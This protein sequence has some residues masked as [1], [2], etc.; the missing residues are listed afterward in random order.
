MAWEE[1]LP[2]GNSLVSCLF[3]PFGHFPFP[4]LEMLAL[5]SAVYELN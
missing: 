5:L 2:C 1:E 4:V 3:C